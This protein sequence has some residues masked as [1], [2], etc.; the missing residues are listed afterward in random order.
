MRLNKPNPQHF[1]PITAK[2]SSLARFKQKSFT[3]QLQKASD[4]YLKKHSRNE[5][6][7]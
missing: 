7:P 1:Q 6:G 3:I 4:M 5:H 2:F